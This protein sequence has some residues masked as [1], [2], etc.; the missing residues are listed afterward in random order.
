MMVEHPGGALFVSGYGGTLTPKRAP[1]LWKST[2]G[3]STWAKVDVGTPEEGAYGNSCVDLAVAP[4]GTLYFVTM[5]FDRD[6]GAGK[7]VTIG[8][9][10]DVGESW[11]WTY[12]SRD[13]FDDRPWVEVAPDGTAHVIWNDGAGVSHA[14]S[15]DGG[16]TWIER[17]R[18]HP[19][20]GSSHLAV[21]PNGEVAVSITPLSAS[22]NQFDEG[23][24]LIAVSTDGGQSWEKHRAP[25]NRKWGS[26]LDDPEAVP[27]WVE[28]IAWDSGGALHALWS[29]GQDLWLG[30]SSDRGQTWSSWPIAHDDELVFFPYLVARGPGELAATWFSGRIGEFE[31]HAAL[32]LVPKGDREEEPRLLA[33][34]PFLPDSW[35]LREG[36]RVR[37]TAGEYLPVTFLADG[38]LAVASTIQDAEAERFGFSWW[39]IEIR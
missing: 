35:V 23:V 4:D 9:S 1:H 15:S 16:R 30:R 14:V 8:V 10:H 39:R 24:E 37:D 25:G 11:S 21:G 6:E 18:I 36:S 26:K 22:G 27:R 12:L 20:G 28:P 17:S 29:E 7:H 13:Q 2:D 32:V 33:S 19:Q 3:G 38:D 5:G 31:A 34:E